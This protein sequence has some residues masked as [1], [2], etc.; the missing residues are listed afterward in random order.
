MNS[1]DKI[2]SGEPFFAGRFGGFELLNLRYN[3]FGGFYK[4]QYDGNYHFNFLCNNAG[5]FPHD[6][7]LL[8]KFSDEMK[9]AC[10]EV[11]VL[12]VWFN[13]YE[14]YYMKK[15]MKKDLDICYLL[16]LEPWASEKIH[17]S[18]A[19]EGK[20]V[21]IIHPFEATIIK[22]FENRNKIFPNTNIL[23]EFELKTL[24]AVQTIAGEKDDRFKTWFEA[25]DWMYEEAMKKD[26]DI[27]IIGCG[28]YG[29]PLGARIKKSGK[30]AIHLAGATQLLFGIWGDRWKYER[31]NKN[32][33]RLDKSNWISPLPEDTPQ[34][35]KNVEKGC[36]W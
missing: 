25:L 9:K 32:I 22:Q 17:W 4:Q 13:A 15:F 31:N 27:A 28:A 19:L 10:K 8:P 2:K 26:F 36:Y 30:Q 24:K 1:S 11:D 12:A 16:D 7:S 33:R 29:F 3:D 35:H 5:F 14:D 23:P 20:K 18:V 34:K 6:I 21:L